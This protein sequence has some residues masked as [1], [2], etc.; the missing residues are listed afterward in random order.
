[1]PFKATLKVIVYG[2]SLMV[3]RSNHWQR[4][5]ALPSDEPVRYV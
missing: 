4:L 2:F 5:F 1:M 3:K